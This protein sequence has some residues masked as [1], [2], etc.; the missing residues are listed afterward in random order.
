M[1]NLL[2]RIGIV[3][4]GSIAKFHL[5]AA[6]KVGIDVVAVCGRQDSER[7]KRF[8]QEFNCQFDQNLD[9]MKL[10]GLDGIVVATSVAATASVLESVIE[11]D[12]P[13]LV[14]K[15][16]STNLETLS[17]LVTIGEKV[18]VGYNRRYYSSVQDAKSLINSNKSGVFDVLIPEL[19]LASNPTK[20]EF[21]DSILENGI[22]MVDL[23]RYLFGEIIGCKPIFASSSESFQ[24]AGI[25]VATDQGMQGTIRSFGG[26]PENYSINYW[27]AGLSIELKPI[28]FLSLSRN[29]RLEGANQSV[30][31]KRY[32]KNKSEWN[33]TLADLD[34]KPGFELQYREFKNFILGEPQLVPLP[35]LSD[36]YKSLFW[37]NKLVSQTDNVDK[38]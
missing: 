2:I 23:T 1:E 15:P 33:L 34:S 20:P 6:R 21:H 8:A 30:P 7:A 32:I 22:H 14:E 37:A 17:R 27:N 10:R 38:L 13:V 35:N 3:G 31:F 36:A 18:R 25:S 26:V 29:L 4:T 24:L 11:M 5:E 16:V 9:R 28:E 12:I 19:S